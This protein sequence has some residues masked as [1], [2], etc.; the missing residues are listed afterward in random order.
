V[1]VTLARRVDIDLAVFARVAWEGEDVA[2]APEAL[3]VVAQRRAEF[4][5]ARD[6]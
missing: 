2:T 1:T 4:R 5:G 3:A 6:R